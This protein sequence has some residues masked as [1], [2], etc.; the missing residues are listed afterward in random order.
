MNGLITAL[1]IPFAGTVL[2][3]AFVFLMRDSMK[4]NLQRTLLALAVTIHN[5]PE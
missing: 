3:A 1:I 4:G 5:I 2:G